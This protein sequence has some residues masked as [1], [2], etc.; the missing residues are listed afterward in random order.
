MK[1]AKA[2]IMV[3]FSDTTVDPDTTRERM[4][5]LREFINEN[6]AALG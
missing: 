6:L 3:V 1:A 5:E 4:E 2:A